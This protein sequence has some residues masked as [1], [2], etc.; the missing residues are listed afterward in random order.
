SSQTKFLPTG[1]VSQSSLPYF[2]PNGA[3]YYTNYQYDVRGRATRTAAPD[4]TLT[5]ACFD[6]LAG[7]NAII[8]GNGHKKRFVQDL[9]GRV[10]RIDEYIGTFSSCGADAGTSYATTLYRYPALEPDIFNALGTTSPSIVITYDTL[11]RKIVTSDPDLGN[12]TYAYDPAGNVQLQTD[13]NG[14][15]I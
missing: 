5:L 11:V 9:Q 7:A 1:P 8:D 2:E 4:G 3:V 12:W 14:K 10:T 6:D 15:A 13:A